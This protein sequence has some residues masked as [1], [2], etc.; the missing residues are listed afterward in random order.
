MT[1]ISE[2]ARQLHNDALVWDM[3]WPWEAWVDNDY[4]QLQAFK[5][6]GTNV[7]SVTLAGDNHNISEAVTRV[8]ESRA[9]VRQYSDV[10]V[11]CET[12]AEIRQARA[13]DKLAVLFH[14]EGTRCF[15]RRLDMVEVFYQL[16]VK[17]NLLAFN[18]ANSASGGLMEADDAGLTAFGR[19]LISEMERVGM[20]LD[21]SHVGKRTAMQAMEMS[22][23]PCLFTHSNVN[24]VFSHARNLSDDEMKACA[25]TGGLVGIASSSM[26]HSAEPDMAQSLFTHL[27]HM[28]EL[29]GPEHVGLGL[30]IIFDAGPLNAWMRKRPE[31]WPDAADPD[32]PGVY[33]ITL[34]EIPGLTQ[35]MLD[36]G[37]PEEAIRQILGENYL[38]LAEAVWG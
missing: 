6:A 30:D 25:E 19:A 5:D 3:V 35:C 38:R 28:V 12:A 27:D 23:R 4:D 20:L 18:N 2:K 7:V 15:E 34:D 17:H 10:A 11:L 1:E 8:A 22:T 36:A 24:S 21:L 16:G 9:A 26:Y 32:W 14:F 31:E 37:Y 13:D 29:L 33:T